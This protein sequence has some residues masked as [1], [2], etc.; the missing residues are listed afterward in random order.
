MRYALIAVAGL[1]LAAPLRAAGWAD[2]MFEDLSKYFGTVPHGTVLYYPFRLTNNTGRAVHISSVRV[3]CGCVTA[4]AAKNDV[5]PGESTI[6][7]ARMDTHRFWNHRAVTIFVNFD[8]PQWEETR[9]G[10]SAES[11]DDLLFEPEEITFGTIRRG[12]APKASTAITFVGSDT[13]IIKVERGSNYIE[14][15]LADPNRQ[16]GDTRYTLTA[17]LRPDTPAGKWFTEIWLKTNNPAMPRIRIPLSVDI[18]QS[19][20]PAPLVLSAAPVLL[21]Q[22]KPGDEA[23]RQITLR[24]PKPFKIKKVQ[25]TD[26]ELTVSDD[27]AD[28][29][30]VHIL[31][32]RLKPTRTGEIDRRVKIITDLNQE[33]EIEFQAKAKVVR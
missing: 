32:V 25:G 3:S 10:V 22:V 14:T 4:W 27:G 20:S 11:R 24:G 5:A 28:N 1:C 26:D 12:S 23:E 13:Q 16:N 30:V 8:R 7:N 18:E 17:S 33:S 9:L 6:I 21:G 19:Q 2:D 29:K 15:A 31:T